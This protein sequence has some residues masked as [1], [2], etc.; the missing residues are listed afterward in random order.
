M[1][2]GNEPAFAG[3]SFWAHGRRT[4]WHAEVRQ[5]FSATGPEP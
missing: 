2:F 3:F 1:H 5:E 4:S